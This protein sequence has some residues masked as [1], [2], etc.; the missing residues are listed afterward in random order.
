MFFLPRSLG[1]TL[2]AR[3]RSVLIILYFQGQVH[4]RCSVNACG[5]DKR[6]AAGRALPVVVVAVVV[7]RGVEE[8]PELDPHRQGEAQAVPGRNG[9]IR[10]VF[11]LRP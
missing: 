7:I 9:I 3:L 10:E 2:R 11:L 6:E 5:M 4:T 1:A 8:G